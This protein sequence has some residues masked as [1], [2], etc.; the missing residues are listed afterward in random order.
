MLRK[1]KMWYQISH[2]HGASNWLGLSTRVRW[3]QNPRAHIPIS[4]SHPEFHNPV[5]EFHNLTWQFHNT[6]FKFHNPSCTI[7]PGSFTIRPGSFT[8]RRWPHFTL[9]TPH[10]TPWTPHSTLH[11]TLHTS[12]FTPCT[13]YFTLH[14]PQAPQHPLRITLTTQYSTFFTLRS[15]HSFRILQSTVHWYGNRGDKYKTPRLLR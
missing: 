8:I 9:Q 15:L 11:D 1:G 14:T 2:A 6:T 4:P 3:Y 10:F 13:F 7:R 12:H 5:S